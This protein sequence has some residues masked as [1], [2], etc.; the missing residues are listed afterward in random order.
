MM[1]RGWLDLTAGRFS[2]LQA[3]WGEPLIFVHAL[4]R[5]ATDW[6]EVIT[7]MDPE[8][9]CLALDMRGRGESVHTDTYSFEEMESDLRELV[10]AMGL[11]R[12]SLVGHSAGGVVAWLFAQNSP[13]RLHHLVLE[14]TTPPTEGEPVPEVPPVPPE[15]VTYDWEARRQLLRQLE[16]PDPDWSANVE[17]VTMPTLL[18]AGSDHPDFTKTIRQ[19]PDGRLVTIEVGHWIHESEP[20]MFVAA[21]SSFLAES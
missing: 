7:K 12:F 11:N 13:D 6:T 15:P 14:D 17:A 18:V 5:S 4:G 21:V 19:L 16:A 3:G 1:K 2:Y 20:G 8:W 10:D 9:T